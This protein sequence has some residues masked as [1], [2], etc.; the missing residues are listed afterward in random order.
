MEG[1]DLLLMLGAELTDLNTGLFTARIDP[2]RV[3]AA[4]IEDLH[5]RR[6]A[7]PAVG[8]AAVVEGLLGRGLPARPAGPGTAA[9]PAPAFDPRPGAPLRAERLFA[10]VG[11]RVTDRLTVIAEAGDALFGAADLPVGE[12]G[13]LGAAYYA[14]LGFAVPAAIGAGLARPGRRPLVLVGDG[15]FQMTGIE[16]S[17][18]PAAGVAPVVVVVDNGGYA[19]E[20]PMIDGRFNDVPAWDHPGLVAAIGAGW[21]VTC[22]TED[23]F[24]RALDEALAD[25]SR[26]R[27]VAGRIPPDD[28][29]PALRRLTGALA[30]RVR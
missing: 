12:G 13:F 30:R 18:A 14:S 4:G 10:C 27:L 21:G 2:A 9:G 24:C 5:V 25:G 26:P 16:L 29:S 23:A 20:R 8:V 7:Y 15:A 6:H 3:V 1:A 28:I 22:D 11:S 19:T 17:S